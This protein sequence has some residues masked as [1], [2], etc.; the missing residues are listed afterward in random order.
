M[1]RESIFVIVLAARCVQTCIAMC[2][3]CAMP[4][5]VLILMFQVLPHFQCTA[6]SIFSTSLTVVLLP[7]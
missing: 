1:V 7:L 5:A 3:E 2:N 4:C 6:G